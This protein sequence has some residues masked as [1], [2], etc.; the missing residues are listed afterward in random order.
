MHKG[1]LTKNNVIRIECCEKCPFIRNST[2]PPYRCW[3]LAVI[4]KVDIYDK[5]TKINNINI[6][7]E[8]CELEDYDK[9][10]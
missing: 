1:I 4:K 3:L 7:N 5:I 6:I 8:K 9:I 10:S 2:F